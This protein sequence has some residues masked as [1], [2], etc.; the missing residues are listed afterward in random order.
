MDGL[1]IPWVRD[2]LDRAL[3]ED[4]GA[5]GDVTSEAL[6]PPDAEGVGRYEAREA[7]VLAGGALLP[8]LAERMPLPVEVEVLVPEGGALE[9]GAPFARARGATRCLLSM[10]RLGLNLVG[11]LSGIATRTRE[12]VEA[13][14]GKIHVLDTR[15]T[16]PLLRPFEKYAVR[17]GGGRNHRYGLHDAA[18]IKDNHRVAA[19][20]SLGEAI[21]RLRERLGHTQTMVVEVESLEGARPAADAGADVVLLDNMDDQAMSEV[22]GELRDRVRLEASGGMTLERLPGVAR[23]GVHAVSSGALT[24]SVRC[25]DV[26]FE[27]EVE[28]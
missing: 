9:A 4:M 13:V 24:H 2:F 20:V 8:L 19:G 17:M 27:L 11:R 3:E 15:K 16:T 21:G 28:A 6:F 26:A 23:T 18:M 7:G 10:E 12:F 14:E 5:Y 22:A 25:L 1:S